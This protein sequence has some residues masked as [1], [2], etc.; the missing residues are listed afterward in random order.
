MRSL[1][2]T[3][4][5][6]SP[7]ARNSLAK[8]SSR[9]FFEGDLEVEARS[10]GNFGFYKALQYPVALTRLSASY[11]RLG[12]R[13]GWAH[14][15]RN[16]VGFRVIWFVQKGSLQVTRSFGN[17][18]VEAGQATFIDS[19]T[20]FYAKTRCDEHGE[21]ESFQLMVPGYLFFPFLQEA[22]RLARPLDLSGPEASTIRE[23]VSLLGRTG[24]RMSQQVASS[25]SEG[26]L[27]SIADLLEQQNALVAR[28]D[29]R[30]AERFAEFQ[31]YIEGN[32]EDPSLSL[33]ST[34]AHLGV[35]ARYLGYVLQA[36]DTTFSKILWKGRLQRARD[37][38]RNSCPDVSIEQIAKSSGFKTSAHFSR[39]FKAEFA[40]TPS[41]YRKRSIDSCS[42]NS[43]A[44]TSIEITKPLGD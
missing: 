16:Q 20:P 12:Y 6:I 14:I 24:E 36:N 40:I 35:S 3:N 34:V 33:E 26:L 43:V 9:E 25:L 28:N 41:L 15:R 7:A 42:G 22:D 17:N 5:K 13:R 10:T 11:C 27:A 29:R 18:I 30:G 1:V 19:N 21:Y 38:L 2:S 39:L 23:I 37:R 8:I 32:L 31:S 4:G 44:S